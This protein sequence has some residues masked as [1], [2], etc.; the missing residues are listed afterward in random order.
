MRDLA[1]DFYD[2]S[3]G[4]KSM[5]EIVADASQAL[6]PPRDVPVSQLAEERIYMRNQLS[7][8][9]YSFD[10]TPYMREVMD[11][12]SSPDLTSVAFMGPAQAGK[13]ELFLAILVWIMLIDPR[14]VQLVEKSQSAARDF[15]IRR[16]ERFFEANEWFRDL[17]IGGRS[18]KSIYTKIFKSGAFLSMSWPSV[19]ELSGKAS[20]LMWLS[21]FDRMLRDIGGE[22]SAYIMAL[23][24][25]TTFLRRGK[26]FV[27]SSPS[28][29]PDDLDTIERGPLP[30]E[31][32]APEFPGIASIYNAGDRRLWMWKCPGCGSWFSPK[33]ELF[34]YPD[35]GEP[36]ARSQQVT[37]R[38]GH[39][40][41]SYRIQESEKTRINR[42][43]IWIPD[44]QKIGKD[45]VITGDPLNPGRYRSYWL[46]GAQA[47]MSTWSD[48]VKKLLDAEALYEKTGDYSALK[49]VINTDFGEP[50]IPPT[51][52]KVRDYLELQARAGGPPKGVVP[53]DGRFLMV[54]V[55]TQKRR[56]AVQVHAV[57][58]DGRMWVVDRFDI[59]DSVRTDEKGEPIAVQPYSSVEDWRLLEELTERSWPLEDGSGEMRAKLVYVDAYGVDGATSMAYSWYRSLQQRRPELEKRLVLLKGEPKSDA[60]M[61]ELR[62]NER[63]RNDRNADRAGIGVYHVGSTISKDTVNAILDR[64][65]D[66]PFYIH[67]PSWAAEEWYLEL[68]AEER[69]GKLWKKIRTRNESWDLLVYARAMCHSRIIDIDRIDWKRP[70]SWAAEPARNPLARLHALP[71]SD[72]HAKIEK[73]REMTYAERR[74]KLMQSM[75]AAT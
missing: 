25:I 6:L 56:W 1:E 58:E 10:K 71:S 29:L 67:M 65:E 68:T 34:C 23:K 50:F 55:D 40:D 20:G 30:S 57:G 69:N 22:G 70:P 21:D 39:D 28:Q 17:L 72:N 32:W 7:M 52:G 54:S 75:G 46:L 66:G 38:C 36:G 4:Y 16:I 62:A 59:R 2:E 47:G 12:A 31:H 49:T 43:G 11:C 15:S 24:R 61:C 3:S 64:D 14:D 42:N 19:N 18:A 53:S 45:D 44:G 51:N 9:L 60:P 48:L 33:R 41:C 73:T 27:E 8:G 37:M 13:T 35:E 5:G 74:A 26:V 63:A